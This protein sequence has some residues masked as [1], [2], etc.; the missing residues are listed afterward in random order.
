MSAEVGTPS[1]L[2]V[3][4]EI[5]SCPPCVRLE[6]VK[7]GFATLENSFHIFVD[8][9]RRC[10][11]P[12]D[13]ARGQLS[14]DLLS[15]VQYTYYVPLQIARVIVRPGSYRSDIPFLSAAGCCCISCANLHALCR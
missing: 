10:S 14:A 15:C 11:P 5:S 7:P 12:R 6:G 9:M 3:G 2:A 4:G 13:G 1:V 8:Y